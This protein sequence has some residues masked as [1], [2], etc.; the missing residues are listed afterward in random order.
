[1]VML[2][3]LAAPL[4]SIIIKDKPDPA[5]AA[6]GKVRVTA[7]AKFTQ[8]NASVMR[9]VY[10]EEVTTV[11]GR[12]TAGKLLTVVLEKSATAVSNWR[13]PLTVKFSS[14]HDVMMAI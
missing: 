12:A 13:I 1:M 4:S 8:T 9:I 11:R 2:L 7:P 10:D 14:A 3:V 6:E 5:D